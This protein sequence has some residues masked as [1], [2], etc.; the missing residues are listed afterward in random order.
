MWQD[1]AKRMIADEAREAYVEA[2]NKSGKVHKPYRLSELAE[3][4]LESLNRDDE[5]EAKRLMVVGR[6]GSLTLI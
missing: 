1:A 6:S 2:G 5:Q 4:L 3:A